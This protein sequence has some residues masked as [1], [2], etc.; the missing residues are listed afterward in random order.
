MAGNEDTT[1]HA[2]Y[3]TELQWITIQRLFD[4][5]DWE[6]HEVDLPANVLEILRNAHEEGA[7]P[8]VQ[9]IPTTEE[10]PLVNEHGSAAEN[11][12]QVI[13]TS[14]QNIPDVMGD[15]SLPEQIVTATQQL[16]PVITDDNGPGG[17]VHP[18]TWSAHQMLRA[19]V[20]RSGLA[21]HFTPGPK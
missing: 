14:Q 19:R 17:K 5:W 2:L 4:H 10:L 3:A 15:S 18:G 9:N 16:E 6:L 21:L 8:N 20:H 11:I 12:E 1:L 13:P 7:R